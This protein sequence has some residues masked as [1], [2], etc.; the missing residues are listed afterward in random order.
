[1]D[2]YYSQ[3]VSYD[4]IQDHV[5]W[6]V[7]HFS[8]DKLREM[9]VAAFHVRD[10]AS[11]GKRD[12]FYNLINAFCKYPVMLSKVK[13]TLHYIPTY[14][15]WKDMWVIWASEPQLRTSIDALVK[16]QFES[17]Q[18]SDQPSMLAK[19]L[20]RE[21]SK[22]S[23]M[24]SHLATLLFP[25]TPVSQRMK[26]YR[27][28]VAYLSRI[29]DVTEIKMCANQWD[30]INLDRVPKKLMRKCKRVFM[31]REAPGIRAPIDSI[32][33]PRYAPLWHDRS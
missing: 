24:T 16:K 33:H 28:V 31:R 26:K 7:K 11:H 3:N 14:G 15:Y 18:E 20:P 1:M 17:D 12:I 22:F 25:L 5:E 9:L 29:I 8:E 2:F 23:N 6:T 10:V 21:G 4:E 27:K 30:S 19:W 13:Q 32:H